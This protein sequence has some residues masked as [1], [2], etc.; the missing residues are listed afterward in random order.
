M[1]KKRKRLKFSNFKIKALQTYKVLDITEDAALFANLR[2]PRY[3]RVD[4]GR[5]R[6]IYYDDGLRM[7][8]E[9]K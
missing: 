4:G 3:D 8:F 2:D 7:T 1:S 6:P 9:P 5:K